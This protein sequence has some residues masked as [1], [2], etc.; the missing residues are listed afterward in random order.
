MGL[1]TTVTIWAVFVATTLW[2]PFRRTRLGFAVYV[3]TLACNEIPLVL[4]AVFVASVAATLTDATQRDGATTPALVL[5]VLVAA[6]LVWIQVRARSAGPAFAAALTA[7]LGS[8]WRARLRPEF[9]VPDPLP[10]PWPRGIL[11][12]FQRH[13]S[14]VTRTR[15]VA[16][17]D[18]GRAHLLDIY[19]RG[20]GAPGRPALIHLHGG[21]FTSGGKSR[22]SVTLLNQLAAH[23][24]FC[25]SANYGLRG[26]GVFPR[27]LIDAK[28]VIAWVGAHAQAYGIDPEQIFLAGTSAGGHL[29]LSAALTA[30][31]PRFQPGFEQADTSVAGAVSLYGY[32][33]ALGADRASS[34]AHLATPDAPPILIVQ[35]AKDSALPPGV[36]R[37]VA[38]A[39]R[40]RSAAAV[41]YAELPDTQHSFDLFASVRARAA[42][43]AIEEFLGWV[44]SHRAAA[45]GR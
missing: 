37:A 30:G 33:G 42:A 38:D 27:S 6:A 5:A 24:W 36:A 35:G 13:A 3:L 19:D 41:I 20:G 26:Q 39:V 8:D 10:S 21:G 15:N 25:V 18:G 22:E 2:F 43:N 7:G 9:R 23:G 40:E 14:G 17:A 1:L 29:A 11:L 32:L 4:L 31:D 45:S 34:P 12:P 44:R 28:R 16:Y